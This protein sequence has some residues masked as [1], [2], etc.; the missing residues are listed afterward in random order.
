MRL[1]I[2]VSALFFSTVFESCTAHL[3]PPPQQC[4]HTRCH[5]AL[6]QFKEQP[7]HFCYKSPIRDECNSHHSCGLCR[8]IAS[9]LNDSCN[10]GHCP[11]PPPPHIVTVTKPPVTVTQIKQTTVNK[12]PVTVTKPAVT[13][14]KSPAIITQ[15]K[16]PVTITKRPITVTKPASTVTVTKPLVTITKPGLT[17]TKAATVTISNPLTVTAPAVTVTKSAVTITKAAITVT[18][19][20]VTITQSALTITQTESPL[21]ITQ[22][23]NTLTLSAP[24]VTLTVTESLFDTSTKAYLTEPTISVETTTV[25]VPGLFSSCPAT[26]FTEQ[27]TQSTPGQTSSTFV[28]STGD[29]FQTSLT[30]TSISNGGFPV[31][32][33]IIASVTASIS[34]VFTIV[35]AATSEVFPTSSP[36]VS[37]SFGVTVAASTVSPV[38]TPTSS[39]AAVPTSTLAASSINQPTPA[40]TSSV[41]A[42]SSTSPAP[43]TSSSQDAP[44]TTTLLCVPSPTQAIINPSFEDDISGTG[45]YTAPWIFTGNGNVQSKYNNAYQSYDGDHFGVLYGRSTTTTSVSQTLTD[46]IPGT[47]YQLQYYYNVEQA[48]PQAICRLTITGNDVVLDTLTSPT[49]RT[50]GYLS[51]SVPYT[52]N[53]QAEVLRFTLVCPRFVQLS[54]QSNYAIDAITLTNDGN[55]G[56]D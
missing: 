43:A 19:N 7:H 26:S 24:P 17:V 6:K 52:P 35:S 16:P 20:P 9:E 38:D 54:A 13:I 29:A 48:S 27:S 49:V 56:C 28:S 25:T 12:P 21:T 33:D 53:S 36:L 18:E 46:L 5:S 11:P 37:E 10:H 44:T 3:V 1:P 55:D 4:S 14:T 22:I 50:G 32:T 30:S 47:T 2:Y 41:A 8:A 40:P 34:D 39:I 45:T 23:P 42:T 31:S 51:R 15:T